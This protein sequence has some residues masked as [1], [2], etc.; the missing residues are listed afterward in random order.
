MAGWKSWWTPAL[1]QRRSTS[2][3]TM[4]AARK[5][6]Q[7]CGLLGQALSGQGGLDTNRSQEL[8][9]T[10]KHDWSYVTSKLR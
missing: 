10:P 2:G 4:I 7:T 5:H 3:G 6:V 9:Q 8:G 1:G